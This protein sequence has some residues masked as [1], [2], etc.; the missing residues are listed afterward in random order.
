MVFVCVCVC[1]LGCRELCLVFTRLR[2]SSSLQREEANIHRTIAIARVKTD[3]HPKHRLAC[4]RERGTLIFA[5][6]FTG[7]PH[8]GEA[9]LQELVCVQLRVGY[10]CSFWRQN[11]C[12]CPHRRGNCIY[13]A[14][15]GVGT[16]AVHRLARG[17]GF[18]DPTTYRHSMARLIDSLTTCAAQI[19]CRSKTW[20]DK[21]RRPRGAVFRLDLLCSKTAQP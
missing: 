2:A 14:A 3:H 13:Q 20:D 7:N 16:T 17:W 5:Y 10:I 12:L 21:Q 8:L 18:P 4:E 19:T 1:V 9:P 11:T 6:L 15:A